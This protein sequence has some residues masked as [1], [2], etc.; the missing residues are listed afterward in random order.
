VNKTLEKL[1][2]CAAGDSERAS[3]TRDDCRVLL[4]L[5]EAAADVDRFHNNTRP[6]WDMNSKPLAKLRRVTRKLRR[7]AASPGREQQ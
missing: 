5:W 4:E 2:R 3:L 7:V 1:E 6:D